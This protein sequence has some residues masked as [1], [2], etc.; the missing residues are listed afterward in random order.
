[1]N[2]AMLNVDMSLVPGVSKSN[3][4]KTGFTPNINSND[5]HSS[6]QI[7]ENEIR[8]DQNS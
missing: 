7:V 2:S 6:N 4:S 3:L 8:M 5:K 1:M